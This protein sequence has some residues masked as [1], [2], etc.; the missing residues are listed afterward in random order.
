MFENRLDRNSQGETSVRSNS[1]GELD[2]GEVFRWGE[3]GN[4]KNNK[5]RSSI[6]LLLLMNLKIRLVKPF[7]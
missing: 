3:V 5:K 1:L 4:K 7:L 2:P 6:L